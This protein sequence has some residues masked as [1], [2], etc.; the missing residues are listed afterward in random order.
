VI[1]LRETMMIL[2]LHRQGLSVSVIARQTGIDRHA[3]DRLECRHV[4]PQHRRQALWLEIAV[5]KLE[6]AVADPRLL[7][8]YTK[9]RSSRTATGSRTMIAPRNR[10]FHQGF[11]SRHKATSL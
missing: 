8:T 4:A 5:A 7:N 11:L 1:K 2:D 9:R 3:A 6:I 10:G